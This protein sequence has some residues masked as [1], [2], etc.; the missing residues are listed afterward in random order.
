MGGDDDRPRSRGAL[1]QQAPAGGRARRHGHAPGGGR[2]GAARRALRRQGALRRAARRRR[3]RPAR[4]GEAA[5]KKAVLEGRLDGY[6]HLPADAVATGTASYYG[7]NVSNRIDLRTME[8]TVSD[9][10]VGLRLDRGRARPREGEGPHEGAGPQDDPPQREGRAGGPGGGD[11]LLDHPAHD[12]LHEHP[13]VGAGGDD[14]RHRGEDEPGRRGDGGGGL[15]DDAPGREAPRG[16]G[17]G[18]HAVPRLGALAV[19]RSRSSPPAP[20]WARSRC[21]RSRP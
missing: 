21:P 1:G 7:R 15:A 6:L 5:L 10:L 11:D 8:R 18:A 12:P 9:V 14:V 13:H 19:R 3:R 2:G 20:R 16:G 4:R 17:R